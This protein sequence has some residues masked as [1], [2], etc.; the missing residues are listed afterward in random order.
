[1]SDQQL[2]DWQFDVA[3]VAIGH[4]TR[5][6]VSDVLG[7][8]TPDKRS[9]AV[10]IPGE[11]GSLPG[12]DLLGPRSLRIE[13]GIRTPGDP[14]AALDLFA[15]LER[16]AASDTRLTAGQADI[17]RVK[18]P[19]QGARRQYGR[20]I[21]VKAV[22]LAG[23][24]HGWIPVEVDFAGLDPLWHSDVLSGLTLPLDISSQRKQGFTAPLKAPITTGTAN[25][26]TRPGWVT[27]AGDRAAWP[28][29]RIT[30]PVVNPRVWIQP[31][32]AATPA[33]GAAP[34][35]PGAVLDFAV[36]LG[37]GEWL[38]IET[39]PGTR[40]VLRNGLGSAAGALRAS[41]LDRFQVPP[42]RSELRWTAD[43]STATS[44]L[45]VTWRDAYT[46]Y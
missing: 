16:T 34:V 7:I 40:W 24:V 41:R 36:V 21:D 4:G 43:D 18:R 37:D 35:A 10:P 38:D 27:N 45:A 15:A 25:P 28:T 44:R 3:G 39:R 42:G 9:G 32:A 6:P 8:G 2:A 5:V 46:S 12:V 30:G 14:G 19:G 17:L 29:L 1:M 13:A 22:S 11:D 31:D 26:A 33:P 20:V 23:V